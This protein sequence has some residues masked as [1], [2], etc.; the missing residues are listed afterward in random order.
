M[1]LVA[2]APEDYRQREHDPRWK[3]ER[4]HDK[5]NAENERI[6]TVV[7]VAL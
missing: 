7:V 1:A 4:E 2:C 3:G 5:S 6:H